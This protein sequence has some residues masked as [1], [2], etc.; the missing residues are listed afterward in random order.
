[1]FNILSLCKIYLREKYDNKDLSHRD[2]HS[3]L[4]SVFLNMIL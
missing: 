3:V 4:M 1:M 2:R